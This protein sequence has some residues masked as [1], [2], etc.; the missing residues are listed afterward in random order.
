MGFYDREYRQP[1]RFINP[2]LLIALAIAAFSIISYMMKSQLNPVTGEKQRIGM[3]ARDEILLGLQAAPQMAGQHGGRSSDA[4]A[5]ANVSEIGNRI[6]TNSDARKGPYQFEFHLLADAQTI[7]A[8][9]L[10]GGQVFMTEGLYRKLTTPGQIAGVLAHEIG[11]VV[12]RH[13]AEHLAKAQLT[14]GLTGAAVMA[15]YD[16][17]RPGSRNAALIAAAVGQLVNLKYG[18][19]DESESD[20]LGVKYM[21]QSG[22]DPNSMLKVMEVLRDAGKGPRQPEFLSTHPDPGNRLE[23]IQANI[24]QLFPAGL[25]P[26]LEA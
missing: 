22:Y 21:V 5:Q 12:G 10:P 24:K 23:Q 17:N 15:T 4:R 20:S 16:P 13:G 14:Q 11:H 1:S 8:F 3:T 6:V 26:G 7:N 25:P 2:R 9:A 19:A 18:R